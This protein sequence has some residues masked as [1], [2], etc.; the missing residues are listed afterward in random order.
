MAECL[1]HNTFDLE[2][3]ETWAKQGEFAANDGFEALSKMLAASKSCKALLVI[4]PNH[5]T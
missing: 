5:E 1:I 3:V 2:L 4:T